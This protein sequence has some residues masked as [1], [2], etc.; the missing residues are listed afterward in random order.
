VLT[1]V[2]LELLK[3]LE[4]QVVALLKSFPEHKLPVPEFLASFTKFHGHS[5]RLQDYGVTSVIQLIEKI[6]RI[7]QVCWHI[8][9]NLLIII[10]GNDFSVMLHVYYWV[11]S[12]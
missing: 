1:L 5:L 12:L 11:R 4:E 7:A 3:V 2:E 6:D 10:N 8:L 9:F